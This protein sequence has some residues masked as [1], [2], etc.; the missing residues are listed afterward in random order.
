MR[1]SK[2]L[3]NQQI[4]VLSFKIYVGV[5]TRS[6]HLWKCK[7]NISRIHSFREIIGFSLK[8]LENPTVEL[9]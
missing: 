4:N 5:C 8:E 3:D 1:E 9:Y 2:G 6:G 7:A